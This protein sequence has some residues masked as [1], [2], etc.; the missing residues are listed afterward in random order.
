MIE[1]EHMGL[2]ITDEERR[3]AVLQLRK[4]L[5]EEALW[6]CIEAFQGYQFVTAT[7]LPYRYVLKR[8]K[9]GITRELLVDRRVNS[10]SLSWSSVVSAFRGAVRLTSEGTRLVQRPKALGDIRGVSYVYPMLYAFGLIEVP[11]KFEKNM[12]AG[13]I[14]L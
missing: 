6:K 1:D 13:R 8:G 3:A 12:G 4:E 2:H 7:G 10:K 5:S 9:A 14:E 11:E